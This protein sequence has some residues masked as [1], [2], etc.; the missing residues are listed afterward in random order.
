MPDEFERLAKELNRPVDEVRV[1]RQ[2]GLTGEAIE[3][4]QDKDLQNAMRRLE[5]PDMPRARRAFRVSQGRDDDGQIPRQA[6]TRALR[7]LD[8]LRFRARQTS[9]AG[10]PTGGIVQPSDLAVVPPVA[11]LGTRRWEALGP[12]NVGGRTRSILFHPTNHNIIWAA[13]AGG[14]VW[15]S[16]DAGMG[17]APADDFMANLA[18][19]SLVMD[20]HNADIIYAGTG[21]G[22]GGIEGTTRGGGIF[23]TVDGNQ[24]AQIPSTSADQ[25]R[26]INRLAISADGAVLLAATNQGIWRSKD[27]QRTLWTLVLPDAA[28]DVKFHPVDPLRAV[29]GS[30]GVIGS[31]GAAWCSVDGGATWTKAE[32]A[33]PW[34]GRVE[35]CYARAMPDTVYASVEVRNGEIWRSLDGGTTFTRRESLNSENQPSFFLGDQGWYGNVIWAGDPAD[36]DLVLVGGVNLW[37]STNGGDTLVDISTWQSDSSAHADQHA[38]VSHPAYDGVQNTTVLFGNDGGI[39]RA[40]DVK[41]VG[42]DTKPPKVAGWEK[43]STGYGVTQFYS[44]SAHAGDGVIAGG[45]QDNGSLIHHTGNGNTD[46][47]R[48]FGGDGGYCAIDPTNSDIVY[49]EYVFLNIHRVTDGGR[50]PDILGDRYISGQVWNP[51]QRKW[52]FKPKPFQIPDARGDRNALF[53]APFVLDPNNPNR[54][55]AGGLSL[56]RTDDARTP[57]TPTTGPRWAE[58]KKPANSMSPI[59]AIAITTGNPDRVWIGHKNGEVWRSLNATAAAPDWLPVSISPPPAAPIR[60]FCQCI[61]VSS[62]DPDVVLVGFGGFVR[63]NLWLTRDGG[64]SW[65]S[66]GTGLPAAPVRSMAI[67]PRQPDWFYAGTEVGVFGSEDRGQTWSPTNEGPANVSVEDLCWMGEV[68][69]CAT[70]GRGMFRID[71]A[72]APAAGPPGAGAIS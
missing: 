30:L 54:I 52:M 37:R 71:L 27:P 16:D 57:N 7:E 35:L 1:F 55:L 51:A 5:Y 31:S 8:G 41:T 10:M 28:G 56:W 36:A 19:T 39:Y 15:R 70:Y 67:H 48:F 33:E 61:V 12:G 6:L 2:R 44:A 50:T 25:F 45:A 38:I 21:E 64:V 11:N 18:I 32:H 68:L 9:V 4:L 26:T 47:A 65:T 23:R 17:W 59:S 13:S 34:S 3:A 53:I 14:G 72:Q 22:F 29:A 49:G 46:W 43:I 66:L 69:V 42:N 60:R 40:M 24:W 62:H 63:E 58:I 20:P